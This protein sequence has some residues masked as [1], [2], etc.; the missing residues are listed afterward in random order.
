MLVQHSHHLILK[1]QCN[2]AILD[3]ALLSATSTSPC[4]PP[5]ASSVEKAQQMNKREEPINETDVHSLG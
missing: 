4:A 5:S 2:T 1:I 3:V